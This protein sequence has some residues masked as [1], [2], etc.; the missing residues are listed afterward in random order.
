MKKYSFMSTV[1]ALCSV[2]NVIKKNYAKHS[3]IFH[4]RITPY[5]HVVCDQ[6]H[7]ISKI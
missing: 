1:I 2:Q 4:D 6:W 5:V 3:L 7:R